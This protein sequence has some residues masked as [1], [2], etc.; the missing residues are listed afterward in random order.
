LQQIN[1]A[2]IHSPTHPELRS[3]TT[4]W[5]LDGVTAADLQDHL[6]NTAKVRVRSMG[7]PMGVR[8]CCHIYNS[9]AEVDRALA[10]A[11]TVA[12]KS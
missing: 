3:A 9:E 7:D 5:S 1:G 8:Q 12:R 10:A 11:R 6:W 4:V 2:V